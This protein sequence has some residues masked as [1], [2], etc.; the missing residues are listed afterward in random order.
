MAKK[1]PWVEKTVRALNSGQNIIIAHFN[2]EDDVFHNGHLSSVKE[3]IE[4]AL[5]KKGIVR[6]SVNG[7]SFSDDDTNLAFRKIVGL[8]GIPEDPGICPET[9][10][11]GVL[12]AYMESAQDFKSWERAV[13]EG[14]RFGL[15][16]VQCL[17]DIPNDPLTSLVI[18][19]RFAERIPVEGATDD[20]GDKPDDPRDYA[21]VVDY[22]SLIVPDT[23]SKDLSEFEKRLS[24]AITEW[25]KMG[26]DGIV[27]V[28]YARSLTDISKSL[29]GRGS[30]AAVIEV[31]YP[32]FDERHAFLKFIVKELSVKM[33][34]SSIE[35]MAKVSSGLSNRHLRLLCAERAEIHQP[36]DSKTIRLMKQE[37]LTEELADKVELIVPDRGFEIIGGLDEVKEELCRVADY[38]QNET[39]PLVP[40]GILLVGPPG[41]GKTVLAEAFAHKVGFNFIRPG[42]LKDKWVGESEKNMARLVET[43]KALAPVVIFWDEIDQESGRGDSGDA[44][45]SRHMFS[46]M[47]KFMSDNSN[48]GRILTIAASNRP[49]LIDPAMKRPGRFDLRI[50]IPYPDAKERSSIFQVMFSKYDLIPEGNVNFDTLAEMS[51]DYSGADIECVVLEAARA[52]ER[53]DKYPH[54]GMAHLVESLN[55][56][57]IHYDRNAID[58]MEE[59]A[60][61]ECNSIRLLPERYREAVRK[62]KREQ[63]EE[64]TFEEK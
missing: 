32:D 55:D 7:F 15:T 35:D 39:L 37:I 47:L 45:V 6:Y 20:N 2:I 34:G 3:V 44:G 11:E 57:I 56:Y 60:I 16:P 64:F 62:Q 51:E 31:P 9:E 12:A 50:P 19:N 33:N 18:L 40:M 21:L 4:D 26:P 58:E 22:A 46:A 27:M 28:L 61:K 30:L 41:T 8:P 54:V 42:N 53:A 29:Y 24:V 13:A 17:P 36:L 49:D 63:G 10:D 38:I 1:L 43:A 59:L 25:S 48:R 5:D 52:A 14:A 23:T